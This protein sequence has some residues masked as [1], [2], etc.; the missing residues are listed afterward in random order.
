M[1]YP[2]TGADSGKNDILNRGSPFKPGPVKGPE[3]N[4]IMES[5][6]R[7]AGKI[8]SRYEQIWMGLKNVSAVGTGKTREG[9]LCI[10]ISLSRDDPYTRNI[11]PAEIEGIPVDVRI[12][13]KVD[14]L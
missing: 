12:S 2:V 8:V 13:G 7:K 4:S 1:T 5:S 11:F 3:K 10:V 14:A 6:L 9:K